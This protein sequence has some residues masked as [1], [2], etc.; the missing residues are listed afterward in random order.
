MNALCFM[1]QLKQKHCSDS[2]ML[3]TYFLML[4]TFPRINSSSSRILNICKV[5]KFHCP[6]SHIQILHWQVHCKHTEDPINSQC[7]ALNL[8]LVS[9]GKLLN[10]YLG[11]KIFNIVTYD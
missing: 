5:N 8:L 11:R 7:E 10:P 1:G 9:V 2:P 4:E 6:D 3:E